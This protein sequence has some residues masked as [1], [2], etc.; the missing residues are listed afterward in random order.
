M[1][2]GPPAP[3]EELSSEPA[4]RPLAL[5]LTGV[6][7]ALAVGLCGLLLVTLWPLS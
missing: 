7:V 4:R 6:M 3:S 5:M 1:S 2:E